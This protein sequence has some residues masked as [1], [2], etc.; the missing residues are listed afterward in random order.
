MDKV[1]NERHPVTDGVRLIEVAVRGKEDMIEQ[2]RAIKSYY[3]S[4]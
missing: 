3:G 4:T 2:L 1:I